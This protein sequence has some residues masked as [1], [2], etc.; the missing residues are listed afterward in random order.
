MVRHPIE[1]IE[2]QYVQELSNGRTPI[3]FSEALERWHLLEGSLYEK[4]LQL[5]E[6]IFEASNIHVIFFE[7][8]IKNKEIVVKELFR[9]LDLIDFKECYAPRLAVNSRSEK[10]IDNMAL[11]V[12][13]RFP[14]FYRLKGFVPPSLKSKVKRQTN[15]K[16]E[17]EIEWTSANKDLALRLLVPDA[18]VFLARNGKPKD[19]WIYDGLL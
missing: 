10:A 4:N 1:R 3:P 5:V 12:M 2:S 14:S 18:N 16:I 13:R 8:Y 15:R 9:F 11:K 19:F 7:D 17:Y 6:S